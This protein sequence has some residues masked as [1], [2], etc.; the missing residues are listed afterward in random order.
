MPLNIS[1]PNPARAATIYPNLL[2]A[3]PLLL[4]AALLLLYGAVAGDEMRTNNKTRQ[5][6]RGPLTQ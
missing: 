6:S 5:K 4:L 2:F 3:V 1:L